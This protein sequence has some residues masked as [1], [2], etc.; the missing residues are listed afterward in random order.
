MQSLVE[1]VEQLKPSYISGRSVNWYNHFETL[2][3]Q[4]LFKYMLYPVTQQ[5]PRDTNAHESESHSVMSH[6]LWLYSPWNSPGYKTVV[7]SHSLLQGIL[8]T[9]GSNPGLPHCKQML[10]QL[11]HKGSQRMHRSVKAVVP[12]LNGTRCEFLRNNFSMDWVVLRVLW[13]WY[14]HITFI[15]HFI[16]IIITSAPPQIIRH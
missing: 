1:D 9:Q 16:S 6:S 15:V 2:L 10:Y 3:H 5:L 8:P 7:T 14:K 11:S 4:H 12:N 13:G